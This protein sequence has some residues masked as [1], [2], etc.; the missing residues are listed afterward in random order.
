MTPDLSSSRTPLW[1]SHHWPSGYDRC[2]VVAGRHVC[3]RCLWMYPTALVAGVLAGIG[4]TWPGGLDPWLIWLLPL[5]AVIDFVADNL[6]LARYSAQRQA[7]L[8][9]LGAVAA[10][11]GYIRYLDDQTDPLVIG[12]VLTYGAVC[13]VSVILGARRSGSGAKVVTPPGEDG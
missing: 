2:A 11:K 10:G 9:A 5:P 8:S 1:L 7:W 4:V 12:V 6:A 13:L 3:R